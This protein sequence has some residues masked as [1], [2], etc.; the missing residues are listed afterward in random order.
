MVIPAM[1]LLWVFGMGLVGMSD[2]AIQMS[3]VWISGGLG[4]W[5]VALGVSV[6]LVRPAL[7][8]VGDSAKSKLA[9]GTGVIHLMLVIGLYFMVFK[10]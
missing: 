6:F 1:V 4:A 7:T 3:D 9:A 2:E 10:P 8:E 5:L